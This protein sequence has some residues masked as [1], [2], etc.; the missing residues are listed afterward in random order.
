MPAV[1][2]EA[3]VAEIERFADAAQR[4]GYAR[5]R[6][7]STPGCA[8]DRTPSWRDYAAAYRIF[9]A[10]LIP[11]AD[12]AFDIGQHEMVDEVLGM[13]SVT[14]AAQYAVAVP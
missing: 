7:R 9:H 4:I 6:P 12:A 8:S 2:G 11:L 10:L 1:P 3:I 14:G 5:T 13:R